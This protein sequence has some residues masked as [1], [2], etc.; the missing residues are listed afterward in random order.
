MRSGKGAAVDPFTVGGLVWGVTTVT[1]GAL[2]G[3]GGEIARRGSESLAGFVRRVRRAGESQAG[4]SQ[5]TEPHATAPTGT[6]ERRALAEELLSHARTDP[7]FARELAAWLRELSLLRPQPAEAA[8]EPAASRPQ[9]LPSGAP[10]FTD[11]SRLV[12]RIAGLLNAPQPPHSGPRVVLLTGPGGIGKLSLAL[13]LARTFRAQFPDGELYA[14]LR[15]DSPATATDPAA[16][17]ARFLHRLGE[18]QIHPDP[19]W[20]ADQY[21]M[22]TAGRRLVMVLANAHSEHQLAPLL[23]A[24]PSALILITSRHRMPRLVRDTGAEPLEVG[25][26]DE[27]D[28]V[29]LLSRTVGGQR[30]ARQPEAAQAIARWC[31]GIPLALCELGAQL[32]VRTQRSLDSVA[33]QLRE[34]TGGE[35]AAGEEDRLMSEEAADPVWRAT[36]L[37]Y[38]RLDEDAARLYRLLSAFAWP[39]IPVPLAARVAGTGE[40]DARRLLE[41]LAGL[42]LL[43]EVADERYRLREATRRHG[44]AR[45]RQVDGHRGK[46]EAARAMVTWYL[47]FAAETDA[48]VMPLR[49]RLRPGWRRPSASEAEADLEV[50]AAALERLRPEAENLAEA[51]RIAEEY[52]FDELVWQLCEALWPLHLRLGL[53]DHGVTAYRRGAAAGRRAAETGDPRVAGRMLVQLAFCAMKLGRF[54]EAEQALTEA[55]AADRA[56]GHR[57]GVATALEMLGLVRLQQW[58]W[59]AAE[60]CFHETREEW[61]AL[62]PEEDGAADA[63]RGLALAEHH[64]GR[65]LRGRQRYPEAL[66]RLDSALERFAGLPGGDRYNETRVRMSLGE[67]HLAAG[68]PAA[69]RALLVEADALMDSAG[70]VAQRADIARL[71]ADCVVAL[72]E[73]EEEVRRLTAARDLYRAAGDAV[74][75][76]WSAERLA[77]VRARDADG[78]G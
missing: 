54:T 45:A 13:H 7:G 10:H 16:V 41:Q 11:R 1:S 2:A 22:H 34:E 38:R 76:G 65:A 66:R 21:Q 5:S 23:T 55:V 69:A 28:A 62:G 68:D 37:G 27:A 75:A 30:V 14:D 26:L 60:N 36:E 61:L 64:L 24:G 77:A 3:A 6:E 67:T 51:V 43:E 35:Q 58:Q 78:P 4:E 53:Y 63:P 52:G 12:A 8:T 46:A 29:E 40:A 18:R 15:G 44:A 56:A 71:L 59:A 31:D 70:A 20:Q 49:W 57:R 9:M 39:E 47:R 48:L 72:G 33:R 25:P 73:P 32:A 42:H 17:R 74:G 50:Q 19:D